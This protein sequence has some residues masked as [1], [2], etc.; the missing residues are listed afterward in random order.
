MGRGG[1][2]IRDTYRLSCR[3]ANCVLLKVTFFGMSSEREGRDKPVQ[4]H[5]RLKY[6]AT[7]LPHK[8]TQ[9]KRGT[10]WQ[11]CIYY[12]SLISPC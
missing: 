1:S 6:Q 2:H 10:H 11:L 12:F 4:P 7:Q 5:R 9:A 8:I 3:D